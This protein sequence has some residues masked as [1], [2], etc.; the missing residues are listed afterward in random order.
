[1]TEITK[2]ELEINSH[3]ADNY[4]SLK[5]EWQVLHHDHEKYEQFSLI[6]KLFS[7]ALC[8]TSMALSFTIALS[9][10]LY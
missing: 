10:C 7:I 9:V 8:F 5:Q 4:L 6:I 1:M 3:E 2:N